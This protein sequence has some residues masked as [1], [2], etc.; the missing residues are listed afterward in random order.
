M[1]YGPYYSKEKAMKNQSQKR[2]KM[3]N[4]S[5]RGKRSKNSRGKSGCYKIKTL[6]EFLNSS[7]LEKKVVWGKKF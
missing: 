6:S 4:E 2:R 5:L 3:D 7:N 1:R